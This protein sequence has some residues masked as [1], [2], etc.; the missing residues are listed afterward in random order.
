MR[1]EEHRSVPKDSDGTEFSFAQ[2]VVSKTVE[3]PSLTSVSQFNRN[4]QKASALIDK[5]QQTGARINS[6][7]VDQIARWLDEGLGLVRACEAA[8]THLTALRDGAAV[9]DSLVRSL[10]GFYEILQ[11]RAVR[12]PVHEVKELWRDANMIFNRNGNWYRPVGDPLLNEE[13]SGLPGYVEDQL[14]RRV[15]PQAKPALKKPVASDNVDEAWGR[16]PIISL[17]VR[18]FEHA[19]RFT[20]FYKIASL[21]L[22]L[23]VLG[24]EAAVRVKTASAYDELKSRVADL[25]EKVNN[26][27]LFSADV[28]SPESALHYK[29]FFPAIVV[30]SVTSVA[31]EFAQRARLDSLRR[32]LQE[33]YH[34]ECAVATKRDIIADSYAQSTHHEERLK[35]QKRVDPGVRALLSNRLKVVLMQRAEEQADE[36]S[37]EAALGRYPVD[38]LASL[39]ELAKSGARDTFEDEALRC[40][41]ELVDMLVPKPKSGVF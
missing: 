19:V 36:S 28:M 20:E 12:D 32:I 6:Q 1:F 35:A 4:A 26:A 37:Q 24:Q 15:G 23:E 22:N 14:Y 5:A 27:E 30:E 8:R 16:D 10:R 38:V 2:E 13:G 9:S 3:A 29:R 17:G 31:D 25:V 34:R 18:L 7:S 21:E 41:R 40:A 33:E 11:E 39:V